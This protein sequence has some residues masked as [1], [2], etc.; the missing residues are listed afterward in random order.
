L[1]K[2]AS[3]QRLPRKTIWKDHSPKEQPHAEPAYG[4]AATVRCADNLFRRRC[5]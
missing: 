5:E 4:E 3:E 1:R 2:G